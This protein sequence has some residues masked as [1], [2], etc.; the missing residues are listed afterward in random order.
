MRK[1]NELTCSA[2]ILFCVI[3]IPKMSIFGQITLGVISLSLSFSFISIK[4]KNAKRR[5]GILR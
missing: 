3:G 5:G 4:L 2:L 1:L